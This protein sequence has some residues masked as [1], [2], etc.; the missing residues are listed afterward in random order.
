MSSTASS[1]HRA[2]SRH[3]LH[4][5]IPRGHPNSE[6]QIKRTSA[7]YFLAHC[8]QD[9]LCGIVQFEFLHEVGTVA[10]DRI[11]AQ[12]Q[13]RRNVLVRLAFGEQLQDLSFAVCE[14]FV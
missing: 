8:V 12:L 4:E 6:Q 9:N 14:Q 3:R 10:L 1:N 5:L 13:S 7:D 11:R 2:S